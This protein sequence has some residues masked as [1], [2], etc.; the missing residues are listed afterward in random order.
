PRDRA[1]LRVGQVL[2]AAAGERIGVVRVERADRQPT[3]DLS[4]RAP[5]RHWWRAPLVWT[6]GVLLYALVL[7][8]QVGLPLWIA[9]Q[10][11]AVYLYSLAILSI[12]VRLWMQRSLAAGR[13]SPRQLTLYVLA[14]LATVGV[15][16]WA[17]VLYN[18]YTIGPAYWTLVYA[19]NWIFQLLFSVTV[20]GTVVG[21]SL[22]AQAWRRERDRDRREAELRL[23]ARDAEL[24][25]IRAQFQPHFVLN[26]LN[27]LLALI[28]KDPALARTMV[29]RLADVMKSV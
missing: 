5:A 21:L 1:R 22:T 10:G 14:G 8:V 24:G 26:A 12:P 28:D 18:R 2:A 4:D 20:Y 17:N 23:V 9:L 25:A 15:W 6:G 29:V 3:I 7:T 16:F 13:P 27:S 19:G 11:A